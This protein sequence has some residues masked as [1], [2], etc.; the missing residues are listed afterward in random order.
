[1]ELPNE[2]YLSPMPEFA[3][4]SFRAFPL[5]RISPT[6]L[7]NTLMEHSTQKPNTITL[8]PIPSV[9]RVWTLSRITSQLPKEL[10]AL[11]TTSA[12][13]YYTT[14]IYLV[15]SVLTVSLGR[16]ATLVISL[17]MT[18]L[19][20]WQYPQQLHPRAQIPTGDVAPG[21]THTDIFKK[22]ENCLYFFLY[23]VYVLVVSSSPA[24]LL[25]TESIVRDEIPQNLA[26]CYAANCNDQRKT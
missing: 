21:E 3:G 5:A 15:L 7:P 16:K 14:S 12:H 23:R 13:S 24:S 26:P 17:I 8:C 25:L 6:P 10:T 18:S 19:V 4:L 2:Y 9:G 11:V 22:G 20:P 1:M